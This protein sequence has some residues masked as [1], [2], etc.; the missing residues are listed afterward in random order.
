M[1]WF[2]VGSVPFILFLGRVNLVQ[3]PYRWIILI[4]IWERK[5]NNFCPISLCL[6]SSSSL[7]LSL[8][9]LSIHRCVALLFACIS[10]SQWL[11]IYTATM[12]NGWKPYE[13]I[14]TIYV[15]NNIIQISRLEH[16]RTFLEPIKLNIES[17]QIENKG[18]DDDENI[19]KT[20]STFKIYK[21]YSSSTHVAKSK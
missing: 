17:N 7:A 3:K 21:I 12:K 16:A 8:F 4:E 9:H 1:K 19:E 2:S 18:D 14:R 11:Y 20:S 6:S 13:P 5:Y 15:M 10:V